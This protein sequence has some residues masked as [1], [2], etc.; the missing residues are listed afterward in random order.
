[1]LVVGGSSLSCLVELEG[2]FDVHHHMGCPH[3][4]LPQFFVDEFLVLDA[5]VLSEDWSASLL[6]SFGLYH[7]IELVLG[8][9]ELPVL[10]HRPVAILRRHLFDIG[11]IQHHS[12]NLRVHYYYYLRAF[13]ALSNPRSSENP[14]FHSTF[15]SS[16]L[17]SPLPGLQ[18][19]QNWD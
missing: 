15:L 18:K 5:S 1:M 7:H 4:S 17:F 19:V 13:C 8:G 12:R 3:A 6:T 10:H 2:L 16:A 11:H 9:V 14:T